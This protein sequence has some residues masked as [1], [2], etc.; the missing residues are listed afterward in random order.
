MGACAVAGD[1]YVTGGYD[2]SV[3]LSSVEKY[4]PVS[5]TWTTIASLPYIRT[6]P[7]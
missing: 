6:N 3:V 4:N 5:D 2:G 1:L 7:Q